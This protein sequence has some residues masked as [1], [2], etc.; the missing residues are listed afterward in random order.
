MA[1]MTVEDFNPKGKR[2]LVRCDFNVPL[3]DGK[4]TDNERIV[5]SLPTIRYLLERGGRVILLSHLGRPKGKIVP[6]MSLRPVSAEL[7]NLLGREVLFAEDCIGDKALDAISKLDTGDCC[8]LEN[9]RF[10]KGETSGDDAFANSLASLGDVYVSEAFGTAHR[11]H[12]SV[13]LAPMKMGGSYAGFLM[14]KEIEYLG[15]ALHSP[16]HPY[17][18]VLGGVKLETK[19]G[20]IDKLIEIADRILIGGAL[21][22]TFLK[23]KGFN[24]GNSVFDEEFVNEAENALSRA[25]ALKKQILLPVDHIVAESVEV[26]RGTYID[27]IDIPDGLMGLDIGRE[28]IEIYK[29]ALRDANL[30]VWNGP[31][32]YFENDAFFVGTREIARAIAET[33][34]KKIVG[35]GDTV[36]AIKK[37]GL[38]DAFD[39]ISTGGGASLEFLEGKELPG[40]IVIRDK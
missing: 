19:I 23:V 12:A 8:L 26:K 30:V 35:G 3:K 25:D 24:I 36:S 16:E 39:H 32:G 2:V 4:I 17:V 33:A 7:S 31:M 6:E 10:H 22:Y 20:V 29:Q 9:L 40:I 13:Y 38:I 34:G 28:T 37:A 18:V 21:S 14:M 11:P 5:R 27:N 15:S 1:K